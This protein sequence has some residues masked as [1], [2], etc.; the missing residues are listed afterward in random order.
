MLT[1]HDQILQHIEGLPVGYRISV[2]QIAKQLGVSEGTAY[3]AIKEAEGQGLVSTIERVGT[4][5]IE[6]KQR[7]DIDRLTF[8]EVVNIVDGSVLG[9]R[10]GLHKTLHK[11]VIGAME[12]EA[13]M[14]YVESGSLMIV[15][16]RQEVHVAALEMGAAVLVTGGFTVST[17][18][19]ELADRLELPVISSTYDTFSVAS[20][21]N[22]AIYDRLIKKEIL[23]VEDILGNHVPSVLYDTQTVEN[24]REL[25]DTTGHSRFP[26]LREDGKLTG[27]IAAKDV[28]G[29]EPVTLIAR[30]MTRQP[31]SVTPKTSVAS[32]A[33]LMVWEGL[34]LLP[35]IEFRRLVG[36]ISRQDV[37]R[38]LQYNQKQP[39][40]GETLEDVVLSRF[41]E[42]YEEQ[43]LSLAGEV[44]PQMSTTHG[45]LSPGAFMTI[46]GEAAMNV[47]RRH[48]DTNMLIENATLYF[49]KP[50]QIDQRVEARARVVD[51]GRKMGK[52]D[53]ELFRQNE[54]VG[55]ALLTV[56]M[57]ER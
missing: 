52:V 31:I 25:V 12:L 33:H 49:L 17:R 44:T 40:M 9:G 55:K 10:S 51:V 50:V 27:V 41:A 36:V 13:M 7:R 56:Q 8:A 2:R 23:L 3:R 20:M 29:Q 48:R 43:T 39:Q 53:V 34:E 15:G 57:L 24:Y 42:T 28:Y 14:K 38:A 35:V 47:L 5:R 16:N 45:G 21:I 32:A 4:V 1:K 54:L 46:V 11:F 19:A 30:V 18:V 6:R 22:R 26:V 37:I